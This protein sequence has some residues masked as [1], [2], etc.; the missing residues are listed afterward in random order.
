MSMNCKRYMEEKA[1]IHYGYKFNVAILKK[2]F[3][4]VE[5]HSVEEFGKIDYNK[6]CEEYGIDSILIHYESAAAGQDVRAAQQA[7]KLPN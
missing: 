5:S 3:K 4:S 6:Y 1:M 7:I 2:A